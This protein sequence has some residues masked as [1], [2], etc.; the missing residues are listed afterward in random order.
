MN[1]ENFILVS[2]F[3]VVQKRREY[4]EKI[5]RR[6]KYFKKFSMEIQ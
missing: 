3:L 5:R 1:T 6:E 4:Y 2:S